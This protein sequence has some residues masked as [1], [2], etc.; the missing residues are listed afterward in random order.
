MCSSLVWKVSETVL[1]IKK[2]R[3]GLKIYSSTMNDN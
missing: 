2:M 3:G 1:I